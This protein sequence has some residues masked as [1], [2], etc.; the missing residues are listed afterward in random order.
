MRLT[1]GFVFALMLETRF[2]SATV[3]SA[4]YDGSGGRMELHGNVR[5]FDDSNIYREE[6][7]VS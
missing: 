6:V 5:L 2:A 3:Y 7:C 4:S 1:N